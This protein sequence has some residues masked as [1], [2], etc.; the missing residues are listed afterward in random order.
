MLISE[1]FFS[2]QGE[3]REIGKPVVFIR[4]SGCNLKCDFCDTMYADEGKEMAIPDIIHEVEKYKCGNVVITGGEP[5]LQ[6]DLYVLIKGLLHTMKKNIFIE[7][8][9]TIYDPS[10]IGFAEFIVSPK[11]DFLNKKY[12][13]ALKKWGIHADFKYVIRNVDDIINAKAVSDL[14]CPQHS[15]LMPEGNTQDSQIDYLDDII[16]QTKKYF[17][18]AQ[19]IPRLHSIV[20]NGRRG[21]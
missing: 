1:V 5:F 11:L 6:K 19:I 9:G 12:Y 4:T 10:I 16:E 17:P 8:N 14:C 21:F 3:G 13:N 18:D 2:I 20:Y 7:T 15:I